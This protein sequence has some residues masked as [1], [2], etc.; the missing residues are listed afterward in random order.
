MKSEQQLIYQIALTLIPNI[1]D[2]LAKNLVSYC[3]GVEAVFKEKK[4][5]LLKIPGIGEFSADCIS[6]FKSFER[7]EEELKFIEKHKIKT[8]FYLDES[9]P[10]RLKDINDSPCLMYYFGDAD[11]NTLKI[12][13]IV[14]TRKASDYGK[15][16]TENLV[17][18][19]TEQNCL[20]LSGLALGIDGYAHRSA[21]KNNLP[22]VGV[23][24]HGLDRIYPATHKKLAAQMVEK[25]GLLTDFPSG[26]IPDAPNFPKRNRIVAGMCDVLVVVETA[27]K[28]G[29][30][31]TAEIAN[32][33]NKDIM[34]L[35]GRVNDEYSTGCNHLIRVNKASVITCA[36]DLFELM[37]WHTTNANKPKQ[38]TL[39]L[40]LEPDD[41]LIVNYIKQKNKI[42]IDDISFDL[43]MNQGEVLMR[44]LQLEFKGIVRS[45]PGK[46]FEMI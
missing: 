41:L 44:L 30:R 1:G 11:L 21:V 5:K 22:T 13:S 12:V 45:L 23:L 32:S 31:I 8:L 20:I 43:Q 3:G 38:Q 2:V 9:Y 15:A 33:Y 6:S 37:N 14:G 10:F 7:A 40:D 42:G 36:Q 16:F 35:P 29:S 28:G 46:F 25:G 4:A 18:D 24:A 39:T 34:A 17:A 27:L 26:T 19:L